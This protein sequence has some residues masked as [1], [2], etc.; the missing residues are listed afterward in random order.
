MYGSAFGEALVIVDLV[1][2]KRFDMGLDSVELLMAIERRF[3]IDIPD[4]EAG[5]I[6]TVGD[7]HS[8]LCRKLH[9]P[10]PS[11]SGQVA[12]DLTDEEIWIELQLVVIDQLNVPLEAVRPE[13][14]FV[15]DLKVD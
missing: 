2:G 13:A 3:Q 1:T 12:N 14:H 8:W 7:M 5:S 6:A 9:Q 11:L 15:Y 10:D 4:A